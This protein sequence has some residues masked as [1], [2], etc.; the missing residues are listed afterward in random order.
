LLTIYPV[1]ESIR[2][3]AAIVVNGLQQ[4]YNGNTTGGLGMF[5]YPP[6]YWW[7]SGAAWGGMVN[8]WHYTGDASYVNATYNALVSQIGPA[9]D[10]VMPSEAFD[11]VCTTAPMTD[12]YEGSL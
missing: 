6:Y 2:N 10:Y 11:E 12:F 3:A 7:E 1:A 9:G 5:P 8:Y 4:I